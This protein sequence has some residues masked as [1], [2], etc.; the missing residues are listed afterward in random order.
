MHIII[1]KFNSSASYSSNLVINLNLVVVVNWTLIRIS[2]SVRMRVLVI[3]Y[4]IVHPCRSSIIV[5]LLCALC[6]RSWLAFKEV[7]VLFYG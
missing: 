3:V 6:A 4:V 2:D 5:Y 7:K 1:Y